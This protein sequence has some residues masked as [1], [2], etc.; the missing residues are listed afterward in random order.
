MNTSETISPTDFR[1]E[2]ENLD[3]PSPTAP[4]QVKSLSKKTKR[5]TKETGF[6][7]K[8]STLSC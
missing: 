4:P 2:Q 5:E 1:E 7:R 3:G 8:F 6:L